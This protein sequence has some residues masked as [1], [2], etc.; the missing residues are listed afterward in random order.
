MKTWLIAMLMVAL[1]A[2][3]SQGQCLLIGVCG[4]AKGGG[5]GGGCAASG[6]NY[7]NT[8]NTVYKMGI[9]Q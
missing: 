7:S 8:C 9:F 4:G 2:S 3:A 6:L 5:G 1:L